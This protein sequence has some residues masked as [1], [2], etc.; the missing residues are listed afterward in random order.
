PT[1]R[2]AQI[3][4]ASFDAATFEIWGA[5]LNGARLVILDPDV[6]L[7]PEGL[8]RTIAE[9]GLTTIL[10]TSAVFAQIATL[11]PPAFRRAANVLVGGDVLDARAVARV[12]AEGP[13]ARL[14]NVYGPTE[15]TTFASTMQVAEVPDDAKTVPIGHPILATEVHVLDDELR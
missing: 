7:S 8:G 13:P 4:N 6:V 11:R 9:L 2:I 5:L 3:S 10:I 14:L 12:L 15:T 1:D